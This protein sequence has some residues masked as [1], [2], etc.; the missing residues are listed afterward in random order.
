MVSVILPAWNEEASVPL[1]AE[2]L[3]RVLTKAEI[4]YELIFIDDGSSDGTWAA[5]QAAQA[6][7]PRVTGVRFSRN[8]GKEAAMFAGLELARGDACAVMDCDLQHP[9]ET[10]VEMVRLWEQGYEVVEGVKERRGRE[11]PLRTAAA[12]VFYQ[13]ISRAARFD[14]ENASDFKLLDR[15]VVDALNAMPE[16]GVFF[17]ALSHWVGFRSVSVSYCVRERTAGESKWSLRAL[18]RYAVANLGSFTAAP[19]QAVTWIGAVFFVFAVVLGCQTLFNLVSGRALEGF[20]TVILLLLLS[21][22]LLM[23]SIGIVGFYLARVYDEVKG[24]PRYIIAELRPGGGPP[25][26]DG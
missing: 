2:A 9:P 16:R 3:A 24:R 17:R 6:R 20:T 19:M 15:R 4:N 11:S 13:L 5:V 25:E 12:G 23:L 1:A 21:A 7:D 14:M 8:F 26:T 10:L 18:I 22:G